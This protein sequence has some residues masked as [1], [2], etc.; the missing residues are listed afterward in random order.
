MTK[1]IRKHI[2]G[3]ILS[4]IVIVILVVMGFLRDCMRQVVRENGIWTIMTVTKVSA[5]PKGGRSVRYDY[6]YNNQKYTGAVNMGESINY[7]EIGKRLFIQILP[8]NP[9]NTLINE[10]SIPSWFTLEA[11]PEGW[12]EM[13]TEAQMREMMVQDSIKRGLK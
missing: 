6:R 2:I 5:S 8:N 11:P 4:T 12:K 10:I 1:N 7:R 9:T 13:P 3:I